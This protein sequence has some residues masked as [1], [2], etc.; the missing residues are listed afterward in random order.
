MIRKI[1]KDDINQVARLGTILYPDFV[2]L[3]NLEDLINDEYTKILVAEIDGEIRGYIMFTKVY[4]TIDIISIVVAE[5][6]R[7]KKIASSLI[8]YMISEYQDTLKLIT[9]EVNTDNLPAIKLYEKFG[10]EII[11]TKEKY[12]NGKDSYLMAVKY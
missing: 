9:L 11:H 5:N 7:N 12:F 8:D 1:N 4:E 10:F 3:F 6:Y 2:K